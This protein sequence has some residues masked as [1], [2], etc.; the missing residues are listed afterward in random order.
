MGEVKSLNVEKIN[1]KIDNVSTSNK[2]ESPIEHIS[3]TSEDNVFLDVVDLIDNTNEIDKAGAANFLNENGFNYTEDDIKSTDIQTI[4]V[5]EEIIVITTKDGE[6]F[7]LKNGIDGVV[8]VSNKMADGTIMYY[9]LSFITEYSISSKPKLDENTPVKAVA[10][11]YIDGH[12]TPVYWV[13]D[14]TS[15]LESFKASMDDINTAMNMLPSNVLDEI[16]GIGGFKGFYV[17][18]DYSENLAVSDTY[19]AYTLHDQFVY[20]NTQ[21]DPNYETILHELGH[22]V[23][24]SI[25]KGKKHFSEKDSE[26]KQ[27][28]NDYNQTIRDLIPENSGYH[29]TGPI[30]EVEFFACAFEAYIDEPDELEQLLPDVYDYM[31]NIVQ[32]I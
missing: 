21:A 8:L 4:G 28:Y 29:D 14:G 18:A 3:P 24:Y 16:Y 26:I 31:D 32:G 20:V 11:M 12:K 9:D 1:N 5:S 13:D 6:E 19:N 10:I 27:Y 7:T 22:V 17:G 15:D 23:D 2:N 30:D 25:G